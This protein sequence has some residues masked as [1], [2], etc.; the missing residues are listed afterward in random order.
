[1]YQCFQQCSTGPHSGPRAGEKM[2][3][4]SYGYQHQLWLAFVMQNLGK[5]ITQGGWELGTIFGL[6]FAW[7]RLVMERSST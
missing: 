4:C 1:M 2:F 5:K 7:G 3:N 6:S